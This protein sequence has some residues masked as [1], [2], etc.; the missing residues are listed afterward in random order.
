MVRSQGHEPEALADE[1]VPRATIARA[2]SHGERPFTL[3]LEWW[4]GQQL[5]GE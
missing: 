2:S 3:R 5:T 1:I 4:L